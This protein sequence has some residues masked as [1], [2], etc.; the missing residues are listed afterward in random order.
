MRSHPV[1]TVFNRSTY[2]LPL[3]ICVHCGCEV[4]PDFAI[5]VADKFTVAC[6]DCLELEVAEVVDTAKTSNPSSPEKR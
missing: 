4:S 1:D 2:H 3:G 5:P 6:A